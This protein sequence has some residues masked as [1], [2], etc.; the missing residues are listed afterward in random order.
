M[1]MAMLGIG[2]LVFQ[3]QWLR[4][5]NGLEL[6][7]CWLSSL[8]VACLSYV[9]LHR[10]SR[11]VDAYERN[12]DLAKSKHKKVKPRDIRIGRIHPRVNRTNT[13]D[14]A[15]AAAASTKKINELGVTRTT[16]ARFSVDSLPETMA[17]VTHNKPELMHLHLQSQS[18]SLPPIHRSANGHAMATATMTTAITMADVQRTHSNSREHS[19]TSA[20]KMATH[21]QNTRASLGLGI[22]VVTGLLL[23]THNTTPVLHHARPSPKH[24]SNESSPN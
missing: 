14:A 23:D 15:A 5:A 1:V 10:M 16:H 6:W 3:Y 9:S 24:K 21:E 4:F 17:V 22:T 8:A 20:G 19:D 11:F 18:H 7:I 12:R 13:Y 2:V